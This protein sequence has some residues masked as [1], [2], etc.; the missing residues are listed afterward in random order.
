MVA[1]VAA[2]VAA[3]AL[4]RVTAVKKFALH[5]APDSREKGY[6]IE[7]N[8]LQLPPPPLHLFLLFFAH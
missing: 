1:A 5:P 8:L 3:V 7:G 4:M 2:A 6:E